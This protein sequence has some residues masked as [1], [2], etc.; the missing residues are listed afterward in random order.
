MSIRISS[1]RHF[2][3]LLLTLLLTFG[4]Q[5][6]ST[7]PVNPTSEPTRPLEPIGTIQPTQPTLEPTTESSPTP[8]GAISS[9]ADVE[10]AVILIKSTGM[11]SEPESEDVRVITGHGSG[12]IIHPS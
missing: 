3:I 2:L 7:P 8:S 10:K 4:C 6:R 5:T 1:G 12:F 11:F 9:L